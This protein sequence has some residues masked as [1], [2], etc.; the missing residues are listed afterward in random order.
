MKNFVLVFVFATL[1]AFCAAE[2]SYSCKGV[3]W[4]LVKNACYKFS[5]AIP[6]SSNRAFAKK[7]CQNF[8]GEFVDPKAFQMR[9]LSL[10][11]RFNRVV[12]TTA[13]Y[14]KQKDAFTYADGSKAPLSNHVIQA[15]LVKG[16][17]A[18]IYRLRGNLLEAKKPKINVRVLCR[19]KASEEEINATWTPSPTKTTKSGKTSKATTTRRPTTTS[20]G[21]GKT[22]KTTKGTTASP[23]TP[24]TIPEIGD[25]PLKCE[26]PD[27]SQSD[28][29]DNPFCTNWCIDECDA[30]KNGTF[31]SNIF[32]SHPEYP[33]PY[34]DFWGA[35]WTIVGPEGATV[36]INFAKLD[37]SVDHHCLFIDNEVDSSNHMATVSRDENGS[38]LDGAFQSR[39]NDVTMVCG[40]N[41]IKGVEN[42]PNM[43]SSS[44]FKAT[45]TVKCKENEE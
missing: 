45:F 30:S 12:F 23:T 42:A 20:K 17:T 31:Q 8:G 10:G 11:K 34:S 22:S 35:C 38:G 28:F 9:K 44:G 36:A 43:F 7:T 33:R 16:Q 14:S 29:I 15:A 32:Y 2:V 19:K 26:S 37:L 1:T 13:T 6:L 27:V 4:H 24:I 41:L 39:Y 21:K 3:A 18:L 5:K 25:D 40:S